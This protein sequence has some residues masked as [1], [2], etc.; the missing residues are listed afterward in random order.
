[1]RMVGL[2]SRRFAMG[3]GSERETLG[4]PADVSVAAPF[5]F[6]FGGAARFDGVR[7]GIK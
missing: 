2:G 7:S 4:F 6:R 1:M 3:C 5:P